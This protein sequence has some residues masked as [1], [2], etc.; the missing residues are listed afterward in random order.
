MR[1]VLLTG[2]VGLEAVDVEVFR[3]AAVRRLIRQACEMWDHVAAWALIPRPDARLPLS[4]LD[5]SLLLRPRCITFITVFAIQSL[6]KPPFRMASVFS[7]I[8]TLR[9]AGRPLRHIA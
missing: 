2:M 5:S 6:M 1:I 8:H 9:F 7:A 3:L 4:R